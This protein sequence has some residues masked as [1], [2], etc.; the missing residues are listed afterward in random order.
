MFYNNYQYMK[1]GNLK[2]LIVI[3]W[4]HPTI[5]WENARTTEFY[6]LLIYDDDLAIRKRD[7]MQFLFINCHRNSEDYARHHDIIEY[8][9][10]RKTRCEPM[11]YMELH[12]PA[13]GRRE[14]F[15][16]I[17]ADFRMHEVIDRIWFHFNTKID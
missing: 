9:R 1:S 14:E 4:R 15:Y 5:D 6:K 10:P 11:V 17:D 3:Y 2:K 8:Y 12:N 13:D 16:S 7:D